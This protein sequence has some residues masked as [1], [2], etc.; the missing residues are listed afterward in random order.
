M[1]ANHHVSIKSSLPIVYTA[2]ELVV[3]SALPSVFALCHFP[4]HPE[5]PPSLN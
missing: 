1:N 4:Q 3:R 2:K 5:L